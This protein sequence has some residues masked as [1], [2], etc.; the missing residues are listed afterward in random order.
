[1]RF[2]GVENAKLVCIMGAVQGM[3]FPIG[4]GIVVGR[5]QEANVTIPDSQISNRHAWIGPVSGRLTL[6][7]MQS[8]NGT[9]LNDNMEAP[10]QESELKNGDVI[11]LGKHGQMKFRVTL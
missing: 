11:V 9:F 3:S 5:S 6:R 4:N 1:M 10:V 8:T 7:D 2:T